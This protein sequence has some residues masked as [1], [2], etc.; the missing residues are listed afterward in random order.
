MNC[1]ILNRGN[2]MKKEFLTILIICCLNIV[3][4]FGAKKDDLSL[5]SFIYDDRA[6]GA[7]AIGMGE[8]FVAVSDNASAIYWNPAG[9]K[10]LEGSYLAIDLNTLQKTSA[11][12]DDLY[13][14]DSLS[15]KKL[16]FLGF[17]NSKNAFAFRPIS[18]YSGAFGSKNIEIRANKYTFSFISKYSSRMDIGINVN[19]ISA[20]IGV[21][22]EIKPSANI[23][24]GNGMAI[25]FGL[26]YNAAKFAKIGFCVED[27]P[28]YVWWDDYKRQVL[29]LHLRT[30]FSLNLSKWFLVSAD[31]ENMYSMKK[32]FYHCGLQQSIVQHLFFREGIISESFFAGDADKKNYTT[33]IGYE[34]KNWN[35]D[36]SAKNYKLDNPDKDKVTDYTFSLNIPF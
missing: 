9:L 13:K 23:S 5:P 20:Q 16:I 22:D 12:N 1:S 28:G 36:L 21:V 17:A 10:Q 34:I 33:G 27:A 30:G 15:G 2:G 3:P 18:D 8:A 24:D 14:S 32:E 4:S 26:L 6:V 29:K 25:D 31:Y 11:S 19:Y 35:I 7:K